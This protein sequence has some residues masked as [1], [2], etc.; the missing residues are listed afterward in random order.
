MKLTKDNLM[1]HINCSVEE[2][3]NIILALN[4]FKDSKY[5]EEFYDK[6]TEYACFDQ[7]CAWIRSC[8]HH[9]LKSEMLMSAFNDAIHGFGVEYI[10]HKDDTWDICQGIDYI[11]L[12]DT[13]KATICCNRHK[14]SFFISSWGDIV[15]GAPEGTYL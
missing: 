3:D 8:Y 15:E 10:E 2:A 4:L 5:R 1:C 9:P 12:G 6:L 11:N 7:T 14:L 13:Y